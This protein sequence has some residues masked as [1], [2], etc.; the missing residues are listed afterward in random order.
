MGVIK[1]KVFCLL[2]VIFSISG[3]SREAGR[4]PRLFLVSTSKS[5]LTVSTASVCY[6]AQSTA[7]T[8]CMGKKK[9]RSIPEV[10]GMEDKLVKPSWSEGKSDTES[11]DDIGRVGR[12]F[13]YWITTT[14][15]S[16][17]TYSVDMAKC[18]PP[19]ASQC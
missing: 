19:G 13:L 7:F 16:T 11:D 17:N 9:R 14:S 6:I 15:I 10:E 3:A 5:T 2:C 1:M 18:T 12:F 8:E 4:K